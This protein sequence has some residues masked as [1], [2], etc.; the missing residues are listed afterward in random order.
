[1]NPSITPSTLKS[2][3]TR[4]IA[5]PSL[6]I[7]LPNYLAFAALACDAGFIADNF[8]APDYERLAPISVTPNPRTNQTIDGTGTESY[9]IASNSLVTN[10]SLSPG[11][12]NIYQI[13]QSD[14][15]PLFQ[16][17]Q[18]YATKETTRTVSYTFNNKFTNQSQALD[19]LS[20]SI[21]DIDTNLY[22]YDS[23]RNAYFRWFDQVT[24]TGI[25]STG[26]IS[27]ILQSKG[28]GITD[29]APYRQKVTAS[30]I[31]CSGL[32]ENCKVSV[33]FDKPVIGV[34]VVYGNNTDLNYTNNGVANN[35]P[36]AQIV[37]IKFD[38]Y[39]YQPQP[40]LTYTKALSTSRKTNTD[41]F[42]VQI[43]DNADNSVVT[44]GITSVTTTGTNN[45]V[46]T[47]TG[48]T[49][50]FKVNPTKTYTLTEAVSGSTN[51]ADYTALYACRR[52][53]GTS[54]STLDPKNLKLTY[55]DNWTCTITNDRSNYVFSGIVF[56]DNGKITSPTKD[57]V[58][59]TYLNNSLYF[60]GKYDSP[61]ESGIPFTTGHTI[62]LNKCTGDSG[63]FS[64]QTVNIN[65]DG[66]YSFNLTSAQVGSYTRFC[67]TQ[68]EPSNYAYSVDTTSDVRQIDIINSQYNYPNN[69]FG[70]VIQEN[71]SLVLIKSQ[72]VHNCSL[73]DL[74]TIGVNYD[75]NAD[76][77]YSKKPISN[78][79]PGQC[80]AYRIEAVNRGNVP[81]TNIVITDIL[82]S[83]G[84]S[85]GSLVTSTLASP[86]PIG[87]NNSVPS[88]A[89]N[90]VAIGNNGKVITNSF[91]LG[92][93]TSNRRQAIRFNTKYDST[94]NSQ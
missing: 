76:A 25:T 31:A 24:I 83:K 36:S 72:Y 53:D 82:Q 65:S 29:S 5:L 51:L 84:D 37:K 92:S 40:R 1:M 41:Q 2:R 90:S 61:T 80:I 91:S 4:W 81:L 16:F 18:D 27:P 32:D 10:G 89:S 8:S 9:L 43:K 19:K 47:G 58:S 77:A 78:I 64:P 23:Q 12:T 33:S 67:V 69:N 6:L 13:S 55:G 60:N 3:V 20:L 28:S 52:S 94:V 71:A 57:D 68:N 26:K 14:N 42:T 85:N 17:T 7:L 86:T 54:I 74:S 11:S 34:E 63:T 88:F 22:G 56:N 73:K 35:D 62:T 49:G 30:S 48:T 59:D 79:V 44:S 87:E 39:C 15:V 50:T 38:N 75:G 45:T 93:S 70:D 46:T 21:Y 66:T